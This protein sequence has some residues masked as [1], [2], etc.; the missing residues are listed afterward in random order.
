MSTPSSHR[1]SHSSERDL[2]SRDNSR[3]R[4]RSSEDHD[5]GDQQAP[6][7]KRQN[8]IV[9]HPK[10]KTADEYG[11]AARL[12]TRIQMANWEPCFAINAGISLLTL[13]EDDEDAVGVEVASASGKKRA[14]Y[15]IFL[16]LCD[17][18][19]GFSD[20]DDWDSV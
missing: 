4:G 3:R 8:I 17:R 1:S 20:S 5:E 11:I 18:I 12:V 6:P 14:L 7:A 19:P 10:R 9:I 13:G 16:L 15:D 2:P